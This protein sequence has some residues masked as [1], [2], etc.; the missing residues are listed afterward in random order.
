MQVD[1]RGVLQSLDLLAD[2]LDDPRM[3][4]ADRHR[5]D[6]AEEV[7]IPPPGLVEE[8]LHRPLHDHHRI[9]VVGQQ[10]RREELATH[11]EDLLA[12]GPLVGTG[13]MSGGRHHRIGVFIVQVR[14]PS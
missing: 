13:A 14:T 3:A 1:G 6:A 4:V 9:P 5:D 8:P 10:R 7:E 11:R 2:P 12:G